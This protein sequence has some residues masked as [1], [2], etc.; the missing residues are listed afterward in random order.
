MS[1]KIKNPIVG[2]GSKLKLEETLLPALNSLDLRR[3]AETDYLYRF[4]ATSQN[5]AELFHENS[6]LSPHSTLTVPGDSSVVEDAREWYFATSYGIGKETF[7]PE[8]ADRVKLDTVDLPEP[9]RPL[10]ERA[11]EPGEMCDLLYGI[12]LFFR[13]ENRILRALPTRDFVWVERSVEAPA[14]EQVQRA[15]IGL[16][17][18][19]PETPRHFLFLVGC[20]WRYMMFYG[21]RGYRRTLVDAGRL[22]GRLEHEAARRDL[23]VLVAEDF[24]DNQIDRFLL[25]DGVERSTLAVLVLEAL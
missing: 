21:P 1:E 23:Q 13:C 10:I 25:L 11:T 4:S 24:F 8:H 7:D 6:K 17:G 22:I 14:W 9:L 12:D 19:D 20:P 16:P 2:S 18:A 3:T 5:I 15:V